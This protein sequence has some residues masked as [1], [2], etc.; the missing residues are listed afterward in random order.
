MKAIW[1][2]VEFNYREGGLRQI[3]FKLRW[4]FWQWIRSEQ[5]YLVYRVEVSRYE[6]LPRLRLRRVQLSFNELIELQYYKAVSFPEVIRARLSLGAICHGFFIG[7]V[8]VNIAWTTSEYLELEPGWALPIPHCF[9]IFDCYTL[10]EHRS[11]GIYKDTL[12]SLLQYARGDGATAGV[13][14]VDIC[15]KT[16][17]RGIERTGFQPFKCV[18][19]VRRIGRVTINE[20]AFALHDFSANSIVSTGANSPQSNVPSVEDNL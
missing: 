14:A 5:T 11:K 16:S 3:L 19:Y 2:H 17:I 6:L 18:Q 10:P 13:I 7:Q 1:R 9:G 12:V 15:N 20:S 4:R 8:L